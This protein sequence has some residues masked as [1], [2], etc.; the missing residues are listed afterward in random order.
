[1][2][3]PKNNEWGF[4]YWLAHCLEGKKTILE[5]IVDDENNKF[6][7][8]LMVFKGEYLTLSSPQNNK[9][10]YV[11]HDYKPGNVVYHYNNLVV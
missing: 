10:G 8:R 4:D 1:M 2:V 11:Y 9:N 3:A 7:T 6:L 5:P